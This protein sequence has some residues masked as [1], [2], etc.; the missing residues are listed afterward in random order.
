M[1]ENDEI[2]QSELAG[3][4]EKLVAYTHF[5]AIGEEK[6]LRVISAALKEFSAK[7]YQSASTNAI[8]ERAGISKGL[9]FRYF[10]D[11]AGLF[12]YLQIYVTQKLIREIFEHT[13]LEGSDVFEVLQHVTNVKLAVTAQYPLE[14]SFLMRTMKS[15]LPE[16]LCGSIDNSIIRAFD[17]LS[18]VTGKL[19]ESL[20]KDGLDKENAIKLIDWYCVGMTNEMLKDIGPDISLEYYEELADKVEDYF[21]FLRDLIYVRPQSRRARHFR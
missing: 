19:D 16:E 2:I 3:Y 8:V 18:L 9:L 1:T 13:S 4:T 5:N 17:N 21:D 14:V 11:K 6:R 12:R 7:E 20:L 15:D 10:E